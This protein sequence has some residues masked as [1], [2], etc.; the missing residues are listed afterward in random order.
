M[1]LLFNT[2]NWLRVSCRVVVIITSKIIKMFNKTILLAKTTTFFFSLILCCLEDDQKPVLV[3]AHPL[4]KILRKLPHKESGI[5][6]SPIQLPSSPSLH[7]KDKGS[8]YLFEKG[9]FCY[10]KDCSI[11]SQNFCFAVFRSIFLKGSVLSICCFLFW[12]LVF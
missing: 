2:N 5:T 10:I 11:S 4:P 3:S 9:Y 1:E 12:L 8:T 6:Y 7:M